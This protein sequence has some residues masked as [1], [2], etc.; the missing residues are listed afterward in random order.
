MSTQQ[1]IAITINGKQHRR[2]IAPQVLL[3]DFLHEELGLSG[4]KVCCGIGVCKACTIAVKRPG[5][6]RLERAQ[7]CI[8]PVAS[9]ADCEIL[10]VEGLSQNDTLHPLQ[11]AFLRHFSFQCGYSAPGFLLGATILLDALKAKPIPTAEVDQ[12]IAASLG[13]HVCRCTGYVKYYAAI[14]EVILATPGLTLD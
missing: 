2:A 1:T 3:A 14:K 6:A 5:Q 10:T 7:A 12:A 13:E 9:L 8:S 11:E 4:T